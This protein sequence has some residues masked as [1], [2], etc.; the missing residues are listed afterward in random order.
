MEELEDE[1]RLYIVAGCNGAGK[2]TASYSILPDILKC[3]DFIN[4]DEIARGLSPLNPDKSKIMAAKLMLQKIDAHLKDGINF[5][6]ETTLATKSYKNVVKRAHL[7]GYK[8][9]LMFFYLNSDELA[10]QRVK[11]RVSEGGHNIPTDVIVRRYHRGLKN[12][13]NLFDDLVDEWMLI[14]NS[15]NPYQVIASKTMG[16]KQIFIPDLWQKLS[17]EYFFN[18]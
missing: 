8:V 16:E 1:K 3:H 17:D 6:I 14:N 9:I 18:F 7:K 15:G 2:T 11:I 5:A 4:A 13:F 10:I 12:F